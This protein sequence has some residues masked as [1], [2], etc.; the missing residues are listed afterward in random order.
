MKVNLHPDAAHEVE[1]SRQWYVDRN[2]DVAISFLAEIDLAMSR[3][4]EAPLRWPRC[5]KNERRYLLPHFPFN[6]I[7]RVKSD[8]IEVL[9]V[10]HQRR[11]PGYWQSR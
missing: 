10:A 9:A 6:I 11:K 4:S 2:P 1:I 5:G 7:Y 8:L 3:I